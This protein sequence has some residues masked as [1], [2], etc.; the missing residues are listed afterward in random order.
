MIVNKGYASYYK[1]NDYDIAV[2]NDDGVTLYYH[3]INEGKE[4]EVTYR[5][6]DY[7]EGYTDLVSRYI[8]IS[9]PIINIPESVTYMNRT[10]K[11][12][13]IGP[14]AF[15]YEIGYPNTFTKIVN[16]PNSIT[17]I[18]NGAFKGCRSLSSISIPDSVSYIG[19]EAFYNCGLTSITIPNS[20][21]SIGDDIFKNCSNLE[22]VTIGDG[23]KHIPANCFRELSNLK[24]III[25][26]G[27]ISIGEGAFYNC[28]GLNYVGIHDLASWCYIDFEC[29]DP[30]D[31]RWVFSNPLKYAHNL[32]L[33]GN[34][35]T[36]IDIPDTVTSIKNFAFYSCTSLNSV[37]IPSSVTRI[38]HI[39]FKDCMSL[40]SVT[41]HNNVTSI[42]NYAFY[43][44][45]NLKTLTLPESID[46]IGQSAFEDCRSLIS[47]HISDIGAWCNIYFSPNST[48]GQIYSSNPL[49]YAQNLF[50]N[51]EKII[52][53]VIPEGVH[54][55][56]DAV[57]YCCPV[58]FVSIPN[59]VTK[60]GDYAFRQ[61]DLSSLT[62][63]NGMTDFGKYAFSG[64]SQLYTIISLTENPSPLI[65]ENCFDN[66]HYMNSSLYVPVGAIDKYKSTEGW[67]K[68]VWMEEGIPTG[69]QEKKVS[70]D[71]K[72][73]YSLNGMKLESAKKG[74]NIIRHT[75]GK[76]SKVLI[77]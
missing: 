6:A 2:E 9:A 30:F 55:I 69:I 32:Y 49:K 26:S 1:E 53:L 4:L 13:R 70:N 62:I 36:N 63:G 57:F 3:Y 8:G 20:V 16:I 64:C 71:E 66:D 23:L 47:V 67:K 10:R 22:S 41:I 31:G 25:G 40:E 39:A 45:T 75:N 24:S 68:F 42:G 14:H 50:L 37:T 35:L 48:S 54:E 18:G 33:N 17:S 5:G 58:K 77:K 76:T 15:Q 28:K 61:A 46:S 34:K 51:D 59:S 65:N 11:V 74:I 29:S 43:G 60:I 73:W 56:K 72:T 19:S 7:A 12:T 38:G 21:T 44:C 52:D 27:V